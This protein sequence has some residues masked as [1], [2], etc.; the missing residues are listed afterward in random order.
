MDPSTPDRPTATGPWALRAKTSS[1]FTLPDKTMET[2]F[3]TS[4]V[5]TRRPFL[6]SEGR[7]RAPTSLEMS[8]PPPCTIMGFTP[9]RRRSMM[10]AMTWARRSG[11][12][13]AAPPYLMTT[14]E[15]ARALIQGRAWMRT[16]A[17]L[18]P[19]RSSGRSDRFWMFSV[20]SL[21]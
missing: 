20:I 9:T 13:M 4:G 7:P 1:S 15:P 2:T 12:T 18:S 19:E 21:S 14:V 3:M 8:L 16:R 11:S 5:V 6:N 10:S 17:R